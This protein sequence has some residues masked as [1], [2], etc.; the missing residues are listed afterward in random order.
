MKSRIV[1]L[2]LFISMISCNNF[3]N[4]EE[5]SD[6][7]SKD[8]L[9]QIGDGK[10]E[11]IVI[12]NSEVEFY[13][14]DSLLKVK[15]LPLGT[16]HN[17]EV[18]KTASKENWY[19]IFESENKFYLSKT[20]IITKKV[21]DVVLDEEDEKT[22]W[23]VS[24]VK[25]DSCILL[26]EALPFLKDSRIKIVTI[27]KTIFPNDTISFEFLNTKYQLYATGK[28]EPVKEINDYYQYTNYKLFLKASKKNVHIT[29]LLVASSFFDDQM[30]EIIFAGDIDGDEILDLI[31][32]TSNHY[33]ATSPTLYLSK[34]TNEKQLI[35]PV[36]IHTSVGC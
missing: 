12:N 8:S 35:K 20:R 1:I 24:A 23:E 29:E 14:T 33:N 16:F 2:L 22:G 9:S 5:I 3:K 17:E 7:I 27:P 10:A 13:P 19:G 18:W 25:K 15:I 21:N 36:G 11:T 28:K 31:I 32:D 4:E 26:I 34:P 6:P 30:I